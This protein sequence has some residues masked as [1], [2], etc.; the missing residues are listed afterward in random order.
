MHLSYTYAKWVAQSKIPVQFSKRAAWFKLLDH[1]F[2]GWNWDWKMVGRQ[3]RKVLAR[4]LNPWSSEVLKQLCLGVLK[5]F[6]Q[7]KRI[8]ICTRGWTLLHRYLFKLKEAPENE[9]RKK[10]HYEEDKAYIGKIQGIWN[11]IFSSCLT[12]MCC[13]L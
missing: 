12:W 6:F 11:V 10:K 9:T 1:N 4:C 8:C 3:K 5:G 7:D 13:L 2:T